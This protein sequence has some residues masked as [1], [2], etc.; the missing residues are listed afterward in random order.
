LAG[1]ALRAARYHAAA[2]AALL[3]LSP[4]GLAALEQEAIRR[5]VGY[6]ELAAQAVVERLQR[7]NGQA[8]PGPGAKGAEG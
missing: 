8:G 7:L 3:T 6:N 4:E 1:A 2:E 5:G